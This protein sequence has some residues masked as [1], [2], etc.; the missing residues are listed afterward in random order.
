M[1]NIT[2]RHPKCLTKLIGCETILYR[3]L[4]NLADCGIDDILI[5]TGPHRTMLEEYCITHFPNLS[6]TFI[7]NHL[8]SSTNYIYSI[9]LAKQ[10]LIDDIIMMHGDLVFEKEVLKKLCSANISCMTVSSTLPLPM[11]D[12]KAVLQKGFITSIGVEFFDNAYAAQP[13][14]HLKKD[15]WIKWLDMIEV[16]IYNGNKGC[17]A[18]NAFNI[19]N[20]AC[21]ISPL[22]VKDMLCAEID[23]LED[24]ESIR[25]RLAENKGD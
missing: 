23:N 21:K 2:T 1:G 4:K 7:H 18:E 20:G 5:T 19:L 17:Y 8:Y 10:H 16:F 9:Y 25:K 13:L 6:F 14:Y 11:K 22:D 24:L 15:E 3:Q 12:F